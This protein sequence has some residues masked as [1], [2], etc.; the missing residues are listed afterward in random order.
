M[1]NISANIIKAL[2][3]AVFIAALSTAAQAQAT[4]TWVSGY[5]NDVN[6]CSL[7]A[8]CKTFAGAISKTAVHGEISVL[9]PGGYGAVTVT[10]SVTIEGTQGA[11][12]GSMLNSQ[13]TGVLINFDNFTAVGETQKS[14]RIRNL[15][16]NGT[17]GADPL[18]FGLRGVRILG[19]AAAANS[20][21]II[22]DCIIDGQTQSPG[23]GIVDERSGGGRLIVTNTT[24]RNMSGTG[25]VVI[26]AA[27]ATRI[28][29]TLDNVRVHNC[30]FGIVASSGVRMLVS[31]SLISN[32]TNHGLGVEGPAGAAEMHVTNSR[33]A[34]NAT[35]IRQDPG[36]TVR[37]ANSDVVFNTSN[38]TVGTVNSYGNNRFAGNAGSSAVV[39]IGADTHDKGQQ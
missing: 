3:C 38:G 23:R 37:V 4:R 28:D 15:S 27:G 7:T 36:G 16:I 39:A 19:A 5:G 34:S 2:T 35:G 20:E 29:A 25:I 33:I 1:K 9:D 10:K 18:K 30:A 6:P 12:Y 14:V 31:N 21:V 32:N 24:V 13:G 17:G 11:G 22:E 8:P 26:P